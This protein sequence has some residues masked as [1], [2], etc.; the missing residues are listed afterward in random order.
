MRVQGQGMFQ[1]RPRLSA[2]RHILLGHAARACHSTHIDASTILP[3]VP[4]KM[5]LGSLRRVKVLLGPV[6]E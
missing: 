2:Y 5:N 3:P 4:G 6:D 1:M